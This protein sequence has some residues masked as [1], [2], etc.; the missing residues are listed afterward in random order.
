MGSEHIAADFLLCSRNRLTPVGVKRQRMR[1]LPNFS[2]QFHGGLQEPAYQHLAED[3]G[4][5]ASD[6]SKNG[7]Q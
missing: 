1:D 4:Q 3:E 7:G 2:S 6:D 5:G